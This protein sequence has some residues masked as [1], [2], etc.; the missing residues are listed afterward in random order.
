MGYTG[1]HR[2]VRIKLSG[3]NTMDRFRLFH[4]IV[5]GSHLSSM[6]SVLACALDELS[7]G[8]SLEKACYLSAGAGGLKCLAARS[9]VGINL[10]N[11]TAML[12]L[13]LLQRV[14]KSGQPVQMRLPVIPMGSSGHSLKGVRMNRILALPVHRSNRLV[15]IGYFERRV[16][17]P[18]LTKDDIELFDALLTDVDLLLE[19]SQQHERNHYE[20]ANLRDQQLKSKIKMISQ[21]PSMLRLIGQIAKVAA[22]PSTV[23]VLGE[24]GTGKELVAQAIADLG[25]LKGTYLTLNCGGLEANILKSELFGHVKGSFTGAHRDRPGLLQRADDGILFLDEVGEMPMEMQVALLRTLE[26]GEIQ[27]VGGDRVLRVN[28]RVVA[29]THRDLPAMVAA[30][31]FRN[32]L[33]QR[34]KGITLRI[35]P[36]RER[37][38]DVP[39]L[40]YHFLRSFNQKLNLQ[41]QG[42]SEGA[43][44]KLM[45]LDYRSGNVREL[46]H[47]I[48]RAMVF[49]DDPHTI[50][51][52]YI[53]D[54]DQN[55]TSQ[56][57]PT[58]EDRVADFSRQLL[59]Q[60][61]E[62]CDGNRTAAM[63][64][65]ALPRTTFYSLLNRYD[66]TG[67]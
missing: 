44:N 17:Q 43:L 39:L 33:Y 29:A 49:E 18:D 22:V 67:D 45:Q 37:K 19:N 21:H 25:D 61:I 53:G 20:L 11:P 26:R 4:R 51:E 34:L 57:G 36:L 58:F 1:L 63:K 40:A 9:G 38:S 66:I 2:I 55:E 30:G 6:D 52:R 62:S 8:F 64:R 65:L 7:A 47:L 15:G 12:P 23:L 42:F 24:S 14:A 50:T 13:D 32:D 35:P 27:P 56:S 41:F 5:T 60:T 3:M 31:A 54:E 46:K 28:T 59:I 48:E 10:A 16:S